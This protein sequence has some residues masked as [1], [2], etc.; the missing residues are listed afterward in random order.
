[1]RIFNSKP[2]VIIFA[3]FFSFVYI[4]LLN[5]LLYFALILFPQS[6]NLSSLDISSK[7]IYIE[8]ENTQ[9][10]TNEDNTSDSTTTTTKEGNKA[11]GKNNKSSSSS[12][13]ITTTNV[14]TSSSTQTTPEPPEEPVDPIII[15]C[16]G[17]SITYGTPYGGTSSTYPARLQ[18][19]LNSVYGSE[20]TT[21]INRGIGG[22]RADQVSA[23]VESWL[24]VDNPDIVLLKIG[25]NDLI[26]ETNPQT[27]EKF[28]EVVSQTTT[29]VQ[30]IISKVKS[31][32][33]PDGTHPK[34]IVSAFIPNLYENILG[35]AGIAIYNESLKNNLS[36]QDKYF[37]SNWNSFYDGN[38]GQAKSS[39]MSDE[40]H[41]NAA[42]YSIMTDNWYVEVNSIISQF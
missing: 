26:Q 5:Q 40:F 14:T 8:D 9:N 20:K 30:A 34:L 3:I 13:S 1:M 17:D 27:L 2:K 4:L 29:E 32:T 37:T 33:N 23:N 42:G 24:S 16:L 11:D 41:P 39:L 19:K 31:H 38:T 25:G 35:S 12:T 22:Y 28:L 18:S 15:E 6:I 7:N 36:G 21:V 10:Q